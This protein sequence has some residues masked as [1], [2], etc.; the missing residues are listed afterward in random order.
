[1]I[2]I[3]L[4]LIFVRPFICSLVY[5][6]LNAV[7]SA[8]LFISLG[9][10]LHYK[11]PPLTKITALQYPVILFCAALL[12]S[13]ACSQDKFK[14]AAELYKYAGGLLLFFAASSLSNED[15]TKTIRI[16]VLA[17]LIISAWVLYQYFFGF[18]RALEYMAREKIVSAFASDYL[19]RKRVFLPFITPNVLGG[20]LAMLIPLTL[21]KKNGIWYT[22]PISCALLCTKS[23]GAFLSL[24]IAMAVYF[25]ILKGPKRKIILSLSGLSILV[26]AVFIARFSTENEHLGPIFSTLMRLHYW[27][28]TLAVISMHPFVGVGLGNFKLAISGF[29]HNS[30]LQIWAETGTA[31]IISFAAFLITAHSLKNKNPCNDTMGAALTAASAVFIIHNFVDFT[32]F[33]P[34]VALIWWCLLGL[35]MAGETSS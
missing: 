1:V 30:Y 35:R 17:G 7:F 15:K 24:F 28:D 12:I 3:I 16:I 21:I 6:G 19:Q 2:I 20:Y 9:I 22:L 32:F 26:A 14:S 13:V 33:L 11:K 4:S 27:Q 5:P 29:A 8:L 34:E 10:Y 25:Y 18:Q 23:L 31:G